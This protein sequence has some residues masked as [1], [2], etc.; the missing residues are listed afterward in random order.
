MNLNSPSNNPGWGG[1]GSYA[2]SDP[3]ATWYHATPAISPYGADGVSRN[4]EFFIEG[5]VPDYMDGLENT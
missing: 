5:G 1:G 3:I 4:P 2:G